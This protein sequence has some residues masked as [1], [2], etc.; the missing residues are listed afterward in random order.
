ME[1][2]VFIE[3]LRK[4]YKIN[5]DLFYY[6]TRNGREVDFLLKKGTKVSKLIQVCFDIEDPKVEKRELKGLIEG[7][8]ELRCADLSVITWDCDKEERIKDNT[9]KFVPLW[10]WLLS[11]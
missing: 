4:G 8:E 7:S 11:S 6:R 3:L 9:I 5:Q 10:N 2:L 1:N